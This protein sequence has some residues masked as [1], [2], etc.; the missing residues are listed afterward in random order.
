LGGGGTCY[1][2]QIFVDLDAAFDALLR[3]V[4]KDK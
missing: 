2:E 3:L 1:L 4:M